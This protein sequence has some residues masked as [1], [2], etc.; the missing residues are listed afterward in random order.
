MNNDTRVYMF[1]LIRNDHD[2]EEEDDLL[3]R[4]ACTSTASKNRNT[5]PTNRA[6][7]TTRAPP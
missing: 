1:L 6:I 4:E 7:R 2:H 3:Y 5:S